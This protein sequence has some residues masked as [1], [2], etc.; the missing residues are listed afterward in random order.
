MAIDMT[1]FAIPMF[2]KV[3][4]DDEKIN[5]IPEDIVIDNSAFDRTIENLIR[6]Q[7]LS[8]CKDV[9]NMVEFSIFIDDIPYQDYYLED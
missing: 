1:T 5:A 6:E 7:L 8:N 9:E 2:L 4:V 3:S